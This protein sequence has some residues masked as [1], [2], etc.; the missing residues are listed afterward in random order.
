MATQFEIFVNTEL[1]VRQVLLRG[2]LDPR[3][4]PGVPA[5]IG[6]YYK[7]LNTGD[8]YEKVGSADTA[9]NLVSAGSGTGAASAE[10]ILVVRSCAAGALVGDYVT[11]SLTISNGVDVATGNSDERGILGVISA[12]PTSTTANVTLLGKITVNAALTKGRNVFLG[13]DGRP[14]ATAPATGWVQVL[15][16][17]IDVD[18][19]VSTFDL[20]PAISRI[21]RYTP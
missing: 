13:T 15:G 7:N 12:K 10:S 19:G 4:A 5:T 2:S 8:R 20:N 18:K 11:E 9:W 14:T 6:A 21:K 17:A 16:T 1:P 3:T